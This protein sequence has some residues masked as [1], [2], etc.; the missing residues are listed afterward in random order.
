[1]MAKLKGGTGYKLEDISAFDIFDQKE[2]KESLINKSL[3]LFFGIIFFTIF[4][5][6]SIRLFLD[7]N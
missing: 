5:T 7:K 2:V 3:N 1:M 6:S 4:I